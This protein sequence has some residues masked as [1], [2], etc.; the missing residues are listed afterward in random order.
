MV[1]N[2][3]K[4]ES[5]SQGQRGPQLK[6]IQTFLRRYFFYQKRMIQL[7]LSLKSLLKSI[8]TRH[9]TGRRT[10]RTS[11]FFQIIVKDF[12]GL[13]I[14]KESKIPQKYLDRKNNFWSKMHSREVTTW[15]TYRKLKG[16]TY[17]KK[18]KSTPTM[19][20][21]NYNLVQLTQQNNDQK[22][23]M[24]FPYLC[25]ISLCL[26]TFPPPPSPHITSFHHHFL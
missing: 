20:T 2:V 17:V 23:A 10:I 24:D 5:I 26:C 15:P 25:T 12:Q 8:M 11:A 6:E 18:C 13:K 22:P 19:F 9:Y 16:L 4:P 21:S 1:V 14:S 3:G 7:F